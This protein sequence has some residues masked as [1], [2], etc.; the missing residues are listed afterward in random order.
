MMKGRAFACLC[1]QLCIAGWLLSGVVT[2]QIV[3][4]ET[5]T[6]MDSFLPFN[7]YDVEYVL[8]T[9]DDRF[10]SDYASQGGSDQTYI[11]FDF[12]QPYTFTQVIF[13]D[14][15]T[16]GGPNNVWAGGLHDYNTLFSY[17]FSVDDDFGNG[18]GQ[19]DDIV[20][21]VEPEEPFVEPILED[22]LELLQTITAVPNISAQ[23]LRWDILETR[24]ANPGAADFEFHFGSS[25][26]LQPGD[27]DMDF[28]FDQLDLVQVQIANKYLSGQPATWGEGDWDGAPG[29]SPGNPPVGD[30]L[31]NQIDIIAAL[32]AGKYLTGPYNAVGPGGRPGAEPLVGSPA[33]G[34]DLGGLELAY[35]PIPEP[36]SVLLLIVGLTVCL[37]GARCRAGARTSS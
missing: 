8:D 33:G 9:G 26:G 37:G 31:F 5:V 15:V 4:N 14:R 22:E 27:A 1:F 3:D 13:T 16:S 10:L 7:G 35:V 23:Y 18:D 34:S 25:G 6:I 30:Q 32:N 11:E 19:T 28:D 21:E 20:I 24:G 2:A 29:G 36:S 17:T 12:G